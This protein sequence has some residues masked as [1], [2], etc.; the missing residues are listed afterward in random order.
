M[1]KLLK[2]AV[3]AAIVTSGFIL[4]NNSFASGFAI[5]E[6]SASG[7]GQAFAGAAAVAEDPSTL[8][9][10][11]A[12]MMYLKGTQVTTG[13]HIIK[14]DAKFKDEGSTGVSGN[15]GGNAGDTFYIPNFYYVRDF[16][17]KYKFGLGINAPFGLGTDYDSGWMGR[18]TS[19]Y[20]EVKSI[21]FNPSIAFRANNK[22]AIGLGFNLQYYEA[23]LE[24]EIYQ[25]PLGHS[26]G[27]AKISGDNWGFGFNGG[28]I[29]EITPATRLG[30]HYRSEVP[31]VLD[32]DAEFTNIHPALLADPR[33]ADQSVN[34]SLDMPSSFSISVTHQLDNGLTLLAD[35]THTK[36]SNFQELKIVADSNS[37]TLSLV[38][39]KWSDSYRMALGMKYQ[40]NNQWILR[41][42]VAHDETPIDDKYRTSRIP[43]DDRTWLSF[44]ASFSPTDSMTIDVGYSHLWVDE[45][46]ID[47]DYSL[48][49]PITGQSGTLRGEFDADVDILSLQATLKF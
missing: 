41:T 49:T 36:W 11:P 44:G 3:S 10:N 4:V 18:Y 43:G 13:I 20:S 14:S 39:E 25:A 40:L 7:M 35:V 15:D 21:N 9:F 22:L 34:A 32:G 31:Q 46:K 5:I 48:L 27:S 17:E 37:M 28:F 45:A 1:T 33:L 19:T 12:G 42:G 8:Y 26:D 30:V 23:T 2:V 16:A 29:Y 47:E 6:N 24:K 38:E